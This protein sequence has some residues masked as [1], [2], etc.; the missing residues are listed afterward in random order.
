M[1]LTS[2]VVQLDFYI[3]KGGALESS[4]RGTNVTAGGSQ[5]AGGGKKSKK[6]VVSRG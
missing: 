2:R 3:R 5:M 4:S 1:G 6:V